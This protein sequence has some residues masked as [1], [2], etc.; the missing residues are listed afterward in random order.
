LILIKSFCEWWSFK[1]IKKNNY[2][3]WY[4]EVN[5]N[6]KNSFAN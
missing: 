6:K 5:N 4:Y 1:R 2:W 3:E